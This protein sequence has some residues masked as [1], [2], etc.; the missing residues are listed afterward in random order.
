MHIKILA[1]SVILL[2]ATPAMALEAPFEP[3]A[4][5]VTAKMLAACPPPPAPLTSLPTQSRYRPDDPTKSVV[6]PELSKA[7]DAAVQPMRD[8]QGQVVSWANSYF[9]RPDRKAGDAACALLW[10]HAWASA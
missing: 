8:F 7:Y 4:G 3:P 2:G 6:D 5:T 9:G 10:I 1:A